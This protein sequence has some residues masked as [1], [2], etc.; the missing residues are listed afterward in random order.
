MG[1]FAVV[2]FCYRDVLNRL[3]DDTAVNISVRVSNSFIFCMT[4]FYFKCEKDVNT[5]VIRANV[6]E[7]KCMFQDF[8][9]Y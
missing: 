1:L 7:T 8:N 2:T 4:F 6:Y 9:I 3:S 5:H